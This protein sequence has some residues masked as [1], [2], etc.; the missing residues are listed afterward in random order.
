[1]LALG[2]LVLQGCQSGFE[3]R[4]S[5]YDRYNPSLKDINKKSFDEFLTWSNIEICQLAIN[6]NTNDYDTNSE[7]LKY[8]TEAKK[9]GLNCKTVITN[10]FNKSKS[11]FNPKLIS[12]NNKEICGMAINKNTKS[13]DSREKYLPYVLEAKNRGL[14]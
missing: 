5:S 3:E 13:F 6:K 4:Y 11:K 9:R 1:M 2:M 8:V 12:W 14:D 10:I 7:Y